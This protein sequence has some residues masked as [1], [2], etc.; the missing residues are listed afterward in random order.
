MAPML[1]RIVEAALSGELTAHI[2]TEKAE[3]GPIVA[4]VNRAKRFEANMVL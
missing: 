1:K 2:E 3:G 4:M